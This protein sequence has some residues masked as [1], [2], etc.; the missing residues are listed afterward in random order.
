MPV[1]SDNATAAVMTM[2][3][4]QSAVTSG[5]GNISAMQGLHSSSSCLS[6]RK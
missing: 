2:V 5:P 6:A 4:V 3:T 1:A